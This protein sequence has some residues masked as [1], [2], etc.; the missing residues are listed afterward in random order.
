MN[1]SLTTA[2]QA[3]N[4]LHHILDTPYTPYNIEEVRG[5][6]RDVSPLID[7]P[8]PQNSNQTILHKAAAKAQLGLVKEFL[9]HG[10]NPNALDLHGAS[11][12]HTTY[13][14]C[15]FRGREEHGTRANIY[16][17]IVSYLLDAG[18]DQTI[19]APS[20]APRHGVYN[21]KMRRL[22]TAHHAMCKADLDR[23][24]N[25]Q[26][27]DLAALTAKLLTRFSCLGQFDSIM[28]RPDWQHHSQ[29]LIS[30]AD[31]LPLHL[32]ARIADQL[33]YAYSQSAPSAAI[34]GWSC[35]HTPPQQ[36]T[37]ERR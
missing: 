33:I 31:Q 25:E 10:A 8:D 37:H 2:R 6:L 34:Q 12:L 24:Q 14:A 16:R 7:W 22:L 11:T 29:H 9:A 21:T 13:H 36:A 23:W 26:H 3:I 32:Q 15:H 19:T 28:Q 4:R 20:S 1:H 35:D 17:D 27:S 18:A 30:I 5:L